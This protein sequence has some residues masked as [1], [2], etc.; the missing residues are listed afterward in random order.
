LAEG[1][2][3]GKREGATQKPPSIEVLIEWI[4]DQPELVWILLACP[5]SRPRTISP[6]DGLFAGYLHRLGLIE[7]DPTAKPP[8]WRCTELGEDV[9]QALLRHFGRSRT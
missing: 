5:Y 2:V 4:E 3:S 8:I 6:R 1:I 7:R 9:A